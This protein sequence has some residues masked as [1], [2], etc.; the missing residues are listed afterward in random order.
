[1]WPAALRTHPGSFALPGNH[2][3][4]QRRSLKRQK[5]TKKSACT[6]TPKTQSHQKYMVSETHV[7]KHTLRPLCSSDLTNMRCHFVSLKHC[8]SLNELATP[9]RQATGVLTTTWADRSIRR[10]NSPPQTLSQLVYSLVDSPHATNTWSRLSAVYLRVH[11]TLFH[12]SS[13]RLFI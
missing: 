12:K 5:H 6:I 7:S 2:V 10:T 3:I 9:E 1:M 4:A 8:W 11:S 13:K